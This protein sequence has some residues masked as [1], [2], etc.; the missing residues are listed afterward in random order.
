MEVWESFGVRA[1]DILTDDESFD[2]KIKQGTD[3]K[4]VLGAYTKNNLK[5]NQKLKEQYNIVKGHAY[6]A[7][8]YYNEN[9]EIRI[10]VTNP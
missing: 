8:P 6:G 5:D 9:G 4:T 10:V 1:M 7:K 2:E 3:C